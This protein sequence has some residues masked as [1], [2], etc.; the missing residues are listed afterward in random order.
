MENELDRVPEA[1]QD[2]VCVRDPAKYTLSYFVSAQALSR[3]N[4]ERLGL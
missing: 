3:S 4:D 1:S 2:L